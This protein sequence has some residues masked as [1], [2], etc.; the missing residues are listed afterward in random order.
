MKNK[1]LVFTFL[2]FVLMYLAFNF[3]LKSNA[4]P[5]TSSDLIKIDTATID[6]LKIDH[7]SKAPFYLK[8]EAGSWIVADDRTSFIARNDK[9][10]EVLKMIDFMNTA[11]LSI[12]QYEE[13]QLPEFTN[14]TEMVVELY[15]NNQLLEKLSIGPTHWDTTTQ[16]IKTSFQLKALAEVFEI[17][18]SLAILKD[19]SLDQ[20]RN[21]HFLSLNY[22]D[23]LPLFIE[24]FKL[25][26]SLQFTIA[27]NQW[28][29]LEKELPDSFDLSGYLSQLKNI[30]SSNFAYEYDELELNRLQKHKLLFTQDSTTLLE[31]IAYTDTLQD[32]YYLLHSSQNKLNYFQSDTLGL[33]KKVFQSID[34]VFNAL[35]VIDSPLAVPLEN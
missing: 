4:K 1:W 7:S 31:V 27:Q 17:Q 18:D 28:S 2:I 11:E 19:L 35:I 26:T 30:Q 14:L 8:K 25:D 9:V 32:N 5:A 21:Q 34:S 10:K 24:Y 23:T 22:E 12:I 33:Y 20:F 16:K 13:D 29:V 6:Y 3:W 15:A